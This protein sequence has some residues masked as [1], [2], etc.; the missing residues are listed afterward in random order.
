MKV[1]PLLERGTTSNYRRRDCERDDETHEK[2]GLRV[3]WRSVYDLLFPSSR[4]SSPFVFP[5]FK[6]A[7]TPNFA[8][9]PRVRRYIHNLFLDDFATFFYV[10]DPWNARAVDLFTGT[11]D[12]CQ[13]L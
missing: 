11:G 7:G 10:G 5:S 13:T 8:L 2:H 6:R 9:C 3:R 1:N 4:E 12:I